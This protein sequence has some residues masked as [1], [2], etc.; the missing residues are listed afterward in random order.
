[1]L[2]PRL[3][4]LVDAGV[5]S[6]ERYQERPLRYEY[7]LT[8]K[9]VDLWPV[10]VALI[11]FGDTHMAPDSGPPLVIRHRD[12]GGEIDDRR[13]CS[14]CGKHLDAHE[15]RPEPGPGALPTAAA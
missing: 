10:L 12:C 3:E 8:S 11:Q 6:R 4:R 5:L 9:G 13:I 7:R 14:D 15:A 1:M 2:Q